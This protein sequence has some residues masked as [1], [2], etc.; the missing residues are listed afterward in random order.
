[1]AVVLKTDLIKNFIADH[2]YRAIGPAAGLAFALLSSGAGEGNDFVGWLDLP[3]RYDREEMQRLK[4]AAAR[5][6]EE[7]DIL[8]VA[9]IGGSYLGARAVIE[10]LGSQMFNDFSPLKVYFLGN[11]L[12]ADRLNRI[13][14]LCEGKRVSVNVISKSGTTTETSIAFRFLRRMMEQRYGREGAAKRIYATTDSSSGTLLALANEE[15][16]EKF[17]VPGDI[18][19]RYSVLTS[20][21]LLPIAAAGFDPEALLEGAL[22]G[23]K[24]FS[25]TSIYNNDAIKYAAIR[26]MLYQK[27][28]TTEIYSS[29]EP[30]FAM[31]TEWLKQL[32]AESH[33]KDHK[34]VFP[35]G[36]SFSTDLHS[37]GQFIQDGTRTLFETMVGFKTPRSDLE[38][39]ELPGDGDG[40]N[41]LSGRTLEQVNAVAQQATALAHQSGGVPVLSIE[42][43]A[44]DEANIGEL[45]YFFELV[46]GVSGYLLGV[47]PFDQPGVESYKKNMFHLLGKPGY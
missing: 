1:M 15:G 27:G 4:A 6:R 36:A 17:T 23:K 41:Y 44:M 2:E 5:I 25:G 14:Q 10:L 21:G 40:L 37:I 18:G 33:G 20:V 42:A 30:S 38:L 35:T 11:D 16:Y 31:F 45:I 19:G 3:E 28:M 46:C 22:A 39:F 47:N 12:S 24:R 34:G 13:L 8:I 29:F 26:H 43:D 7:S 32:F 9:G